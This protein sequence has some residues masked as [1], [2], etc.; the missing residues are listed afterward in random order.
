MF[1]AI[2]NV[3]EQMMSGNMDSSTIGQAVGDHLDSV[4]TDQLADHLQTA[5][6]NLQENGQT[7]YAQQATA[8]VEQIR[9]NPSGAKDAVVAF[10]QTNPQLLQHFSP[11][12]VGG[13]ASKLG[14]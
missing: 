12:F 4:G 10:I 14:L 5:A 6:S 8:L 11:E 1:D 2:K 7:N 3:A 13:I 9:T